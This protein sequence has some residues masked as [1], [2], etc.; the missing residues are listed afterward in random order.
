MV[1]ADA[2]QIAISFSEESFLYLP[3]NGDSSKTVDRKLETKLKEM[4]Q[5]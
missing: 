4:P 3:N 1:V 2:K 5:A